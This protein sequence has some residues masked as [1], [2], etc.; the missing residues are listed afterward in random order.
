MADEMKRI[1]FLK[2]WNKLEI[3]TDQTKEE[4]KKMLLPE[5]K[6]IDQMWNEQGPLQQIS[7]ATG[8]AY[9]V[10][11]IDDYYAKVRA[12]ETELARLVEKMK[13]ELVTETRI[14]VG[15][16]IPTYKPYTDEEFKNELSNS[17]AR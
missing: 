5:F 15:T 8:Q 9:K 16:P 1:L 11:T 17:Q 3:R 2:H 10:K 13:E 14:L 12:H 7:T 4:L 6:K